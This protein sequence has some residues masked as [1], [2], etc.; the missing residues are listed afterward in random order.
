MAKGF[1]LFF[2]VK[3]CT[4]FLFFFF[5]VD[6]FS[7]QQKVLETTT[8]TKMTNKMTKKNDQQK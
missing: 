3:Y 4:D 6:V 2:F 8:T 7:P 1:I 5:S